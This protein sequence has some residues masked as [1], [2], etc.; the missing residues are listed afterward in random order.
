MGGLGLGGLMGDV[1]PDSP[2]RLLA[3]AL[4]ARPPAEPWAAPFVTAEIGRY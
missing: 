1:A 3:G 2:E 4:Q